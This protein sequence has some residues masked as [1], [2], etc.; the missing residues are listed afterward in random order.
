MKFHSLMCY[1][2]ESTLL[3]AGNTRAR[4]HTHTHTHIQKR[5]KSD[6]A[7]FTWYTV[8]NANAAVV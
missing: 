1:P 6:R 3:L 2:E 7:I 8:D 5:C 4:A